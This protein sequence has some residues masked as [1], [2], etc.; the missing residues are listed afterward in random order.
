MQENLFDNIE[1]TYTPSAGTYVNGFLNAQPF[2]DWEMDRLPYA[3][4]FW[5]TIA[6]HK[7]QAARE[8][9]ENIKEDVDSEIDD[10]R[11]N[12]K[13]SELDE[14]HEIISGMS[15]YPSDCDDGNHDHDVRLEVDIPHWMT[16]TDRKTYA[17]LMDLIEE[18]VRASVAS[19]RD[20]K[21]AQED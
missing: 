7:E 14:V 6:K 20:W 11:D 19:Y 9:Y 10:I 5:A 1:I 13:N 18:K 2:E 8:V 4:R 17:E 12:A 3:D 21:E 16:K 15:F